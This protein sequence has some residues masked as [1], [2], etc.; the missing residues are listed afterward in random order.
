MTGGLGPAER[1]RVGRLAAPRGRAARAA[2]PAEIETSLKQLD[3]K[4]G[5][6]IVRTFDI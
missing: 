5:G 2:S 1:H 6:P 3:K 4:Q